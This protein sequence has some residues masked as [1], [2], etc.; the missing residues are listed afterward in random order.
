MDNAAIAAKIEELI[1]YAN[2]ELCLPS[3]DAAYARNRLLD[4]LDIK[5]PAE[6]VKAYGELQTILDPILTYAAKAGICD[7]TETAKILFETRMLG[8]LAPPPSFISGEFRRIAL[9]GGVEKATNFLSD[10]SI[11]SNYI[12]MCDIRKNICWE[13]RGAFGRIVVTINRSKPEK[14]PKDI[15]K[16]KNTPKGAYP[17][18]PLCKE[19]VGFAGNVNQAARQTLRTVP[20]VLNGQPWQLQF[21]P[22][23]YYE[24]H[25]IALSD[26]HRP[27]KVNQ[28]TFIKMLDFVDL[29]PHFF[30]GSNAALP[31]VGGSI[32]AHDHFQ[33]GAKVLPT[34]EASNRRSF[35]NRRFKNVSL[36]ILDW[37][38]SVIRLSSKNRKDLSDYAA[39]ILET[40]EAYDDE[41]ADILHKTADAP[42]NAVTPIVRREVDG[43]YILDM[44]LRNN[45]TDQSRPFGIFHPPAEYHN[46]KKEG[47]GIIEVMGL[48]ILPGRLFE[49]TR[50]IASYRFGEKKL[51]PAAL[52][53]ENDPL[54]KHKDALTALIDKYGTR[55]SKKEAEEAVTDYINKTCEKILECTAVFKN[56][57]E[58]QRAFKRFIDNIL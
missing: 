49:E 33:G 7:D 19:N 14:D 45:R 31:I 1:A 37:Y 6:P 16:A 32:L 23:V 47:I 56:T 22:Y 43:T 35:S 57:D 26:E 5:E 17:K 25:C 20:I 39:F 44:I 30:I 15:E 29:F 42:H 27:M 53:I 52:S 18:C 48:F 8:L 58:G 24:K 41:S 34:F 28:A 11:K 3:D 40:W 4:L 38:N 10:Y 12:R 21:S 13:T 9:S 54:H 51:D 36:S 55:L 46:I 2:A 50:L